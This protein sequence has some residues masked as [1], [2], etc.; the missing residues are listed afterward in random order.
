MLSTVN[1]F[2]RYFSPPKFIKSASLLKKFNSSF[3]DLKKQLNVTDIWSLNKIYLY[4][5]AH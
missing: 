2:A 3:H 1:V 5:I 4:I